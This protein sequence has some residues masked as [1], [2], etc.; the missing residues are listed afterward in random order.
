MIIGTAGHIDHGK[1]TLVEAL[2]GVR[3]DRLREERERGITIELNFAPFA[4]ANGLNA[5]I[6]DVPGHEDFV[7][8][9]VA[10]ASGIDLVLLVIAADEGIMPQTREHLAI[11]EQL[12]ISTGIP[13]LTK[14][15]LVEAEWLEL[16][17]LEIGEWLERSPIRFG[18][19]LG[20]SSITGLGID[21]LRAAIQQIAESLPPRDLD[22]LFRLPVD[23]S[24]SIAGI[25][26]VVTGTAWSGTIR[27]GD[28]VMVMPGRTQARV[29]SVE[30]HSR[31]A[32]SAEPGMRVALGLAGIDRDELRRGDVITNFPSAWHPTTALDVE[33]TL[34]PDAKRGLNQ[35]TRVR[36]HLGTAEVVARVSP[37]AHIEPGTSG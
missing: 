27:P 15:D 29:R 19:P 18:P 20:V 24:F 12:G 5:G 23:R 31:E 9:M 28:Q 3:M 22:D 36:L 25:G 1:S 13:V 37:L 34:L 8:T 6:V 26:T 21:A 4:L 2:T 11:A 16:L 35:R 17:E 14:V 10:G 32:P 7:R 33:I 30:M